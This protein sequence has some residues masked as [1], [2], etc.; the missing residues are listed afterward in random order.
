M[1]WSATRSR[2]EMLELREARSTDAQICLRAETSEIVR[3]L[4][5]QRH[6]DPVY[7]LL[8]APSARDALR[9]ARLFPWFL[10][11]LQR[12]MKSL[13]SLQT[14]VH[15]LQE[16]T[17]A[18]RRLQEKQLQSLAASRKANQRSRRE[19]EQGAKELQTA[20]AAVNEELRNLQAD[21]GARTGA[22]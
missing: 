18:E 15:N 1:R 4:Y 9:R 11:G 19:S 17:L 20:R 12:R 8:S 16:S 14:L 2:L 6:N 21:R 5:A 13:D 10:Q 22:F 3:S 7:W